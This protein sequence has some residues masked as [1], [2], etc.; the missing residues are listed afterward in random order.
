MVKQLVVEVFSY[1]LGVIQAKL[2]SSQLLTHNYFLSLTQNKITRC[3]NVL[4]DEY[5]S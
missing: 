3:L 4:I 5:C 1:E 2:F